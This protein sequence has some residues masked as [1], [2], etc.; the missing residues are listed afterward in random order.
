MGKDS[1]RDSRPLFGLLSTTIA[2]ALPLCRFLA[3]SLHRN[4]ISQQSRT[5]P[6][7]IKFKMNVR[8]VISDRTGGDGGLF[9]CGSQTS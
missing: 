6:S 8:S 4:R 1:G 2:V 3:S 5:A 7:V 9:K